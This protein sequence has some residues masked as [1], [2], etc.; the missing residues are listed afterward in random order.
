MCGAAGTDEIRVV[1]VR[2]PVGPASRRGHD[3]VLLEAK[4]GT[5][6]ARGD[7]DVRDGVGALGVRDRVPAPVEDPEL[8]AFPSGERGDERCSVGFRAA[9]L[10]MERARAAE[11]AGAEQGAAEVGAAAAGA[12]DHSPRWVRERSEPRAEDAGLVQHLERPVVPGDVEL[13]AR[14]PVERA[15]TVGPD[16]RGDP[17]LAEEAEGSAG[18]GGLGDVEVHRD[19]AAPT[20]VDASGRVKE[21]GE[22]GEPV[23][24]AQRR[25][26]GQLGAEILRE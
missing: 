8:G 9:D 24:V 21:P 12:G 3:G 1:S 13:V 7:E 14:R 23:A 10:Q 2:E 25:D 4:D 26:R 18:D 17:E 20:E 6:R 19:L 11:G 22:L 15:S 16:F 5:A